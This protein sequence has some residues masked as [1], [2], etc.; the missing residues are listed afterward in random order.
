MFYIK[1][2]LFGGNANNGAVV[3]FGCSTSNHNPHF[4]HTEQ[5][6]V[7]SFGCS[8]SNHNT[9]AADHFNHQVVSFGCSTS[10]HNH[11]QPG[12]ER[13]VLFLLDVLHQTTTGD[14]PSK[15]MR[16][17]FLLDVLH[18]TT[19]MY[20]VGLRAAGCFFWMF[21]IKPQL[22]RMARAVVSVVSFGCST[23]NHNSA[24]RLAGMVS[25]VSFGCSTSNHNP[26]R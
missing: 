11:F 3:S 4:S 8:T 19:T 12:L 9:Q 2:Q 5:R 25:V 23:S 26:C 17:L 22:S 6:Q 13:R 15:S 18:Q 21:Y 10:N 16:S 1:P 20:D 14:A 24:T 7:V